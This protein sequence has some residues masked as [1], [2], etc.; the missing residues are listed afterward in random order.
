MPHNLG[1]IWAA[2]LQFCWMVSLLNGLD[3]FF[4]KVF[5]LSVN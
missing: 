5:L 2:G 1:T 4:Y 3:D